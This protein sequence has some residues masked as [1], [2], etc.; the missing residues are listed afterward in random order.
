MP[1]SKESQVE[2]S[3]SS[4][5]RKEP[6]SLLSFLSS[7]FKIPVAASKK[8]RGVLQHF[9]VPD[10]VATDIPVST[11]APANPFSFLRIV[12]A[13]RKDSWKLFAADDNDLGEVDEFECE[14]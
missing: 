14:L 9:L 3:S 8:L 11:P 7:S 13:V 2:K 10:P 12:G 6:V 4:L 1:S 5:P